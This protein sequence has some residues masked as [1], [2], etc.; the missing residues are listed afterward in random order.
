MVTVP[1]GVNLMALAMRLTSVRLSLFS[2][3]E[4]SGRSAAISVTSTICPSPASL[5]ASPELQAE[6]NEWE[7]VWEATFAALR[8]VVDVVLPIEFADV[9]RA[10]R[11]LMTTPG[12]SARDALHVA[13]MQGHDIGRIMSFDAGFDR[14]SGIHRIA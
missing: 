11:L 5:G 13:V 12:L 10:R 7:R 1:A 4:K 8:A 3:P 14:I 9:E 6:F 2:S